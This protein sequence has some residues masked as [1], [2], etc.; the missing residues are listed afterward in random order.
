MNIWQKQPG[1][2]TV[3]ETYSEPFQTPKMELFVKRANG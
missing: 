1:R 2:S 3:F